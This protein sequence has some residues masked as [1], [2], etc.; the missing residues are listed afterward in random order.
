MHRVRT[1]LGVLAAATTLLT[2][3]L[4]MPAPASAAAAV[5]ACYDYPIAT[6]EKG[7]SDTA[8]IDCAGPHTAETWFVGTLPES[9]GL[10]SKAS[11][12]LRLAAGRPCTVA[13]MNAFLGMPDRKLPSR[14]IPV[15]LLPTDAQWA[16]GD[17]W[18]RCDAVLQSGLALQPIT[19]TAPAFVAAT[20][21]EV[22]NFCTPLT[23]SA[24]S[25]W[26]VQCTNPKKNWIKVLDQELGGPTAK[27][28]GESTVLRRSATICQK[29]AKQ[30]NGKATF[31]GWWRINPTAA[32]WKQG[33]RAVQCF[34]PY[35]QYLA[36]IAQNTPAPA[37][38]P[39]EPAP[40]P[41][42]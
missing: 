9:F 21:Q 11:A 41:T 13:A 35:S 19:G 29:I 6:L 25:K 32:G 38:A 8:P 37:P 10:P 42:A 4:V 12:T 1:G 28:P 36:E 23:P 3:G 30:Y 40:A 24:K 7:S 22:L 2:A 31:P 17:R 15:A 33:K 20:P 39:T 27:F 5:G 34:V 14:F 16:T 18:V 26:A